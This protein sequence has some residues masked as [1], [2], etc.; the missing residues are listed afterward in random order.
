MKNIAIIPARSGSK[1]LKDKNI[2]MI[3]G[4][5]LI[6]YT[7]EAAKN[8]N[9]FA[10]IFVSTDSDEYAQIAEK[11]GASV[12][13]LRNPEL[14][15]DHS[16]SWDVVLESL[17]KYGEI[18][19][20][21]DSFALLQPTSPLRTGDDIAAGYKLMRDKEANAVVSV[22][23]AEPSPLWCGTLPSDLSLTNFINPEYLSMPRQALPVYYR[24]NGALY[25]AKTAYFKEF[26]NI[27]HAG[28]YAYI[29]D[30]MSS[31]DIDTEIDFAL[32]EALLCKSGRK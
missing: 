21:Y 8:S 25:I 3:N 2:K 17:N 11:C 28:C 31:V 27:Y 15:R 12:P 26:G 6:A 22:C 24:V 9:L 13:F 29:M 23:E 4:R 7:I 14:G 18:G 19:L 10:E 16:S 32:A 1:G 20:T 5:P 30:A